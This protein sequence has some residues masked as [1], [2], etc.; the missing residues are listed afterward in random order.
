MARKERKTKIA[1][2]VFQDLLGQIL[3]ERYV[4]G[5]RLPPERDLSSRL[6]TNRN[7][8]R[9]AIRRLEQSHLVTVRQGQGVTVANFRQTGHID[10]FEPFLAY[11][12]DAEEKERAL[13]D[14]LAARTWV[15]GYALTLA[16]ERADQSDFRKLRD[17]R[18]L[19]AA[20]FTSRDREALAVGYQ[21]WLEIVIDSAH[22]LP[23]RWVANPFLDLNR[24]FIDR[25][26]S[27]W[28]LDELFPEY[29]DVTERAI[30][31]G[32]LPSAVEINRVYYDKIDALVIDMLRQLFAAVPPEWSG[33]GGDR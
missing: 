7:T 24:S 4:A 1:D 23:I 13:R 18:T 26:P 19:L 12:A 29:L 30:R 28:V 17:L 22:S 16:V 9:E 32:D 25:F 3:G 10:I 33:A 6:G 21:Q 8:L 14:L 20:A 2:E 15:L 31:E 11:G 27:L 5:E